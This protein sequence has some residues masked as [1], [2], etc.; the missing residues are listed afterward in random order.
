MG[1]PPPD[2]NRSQRNAAETLDLDAGTAA[3]APGRNAPAN[4]L[5]AARPADHPA[6]DVGDRYEIRHEHARGSHARVLLAFD[7]HTGR[8]VALKEPLAT[9]PSGLPADERAHRFLREARTTAQL[10]HPHIVPVH[11]IGRS[12]DGAPFY[13]MR[14]VRGETLAARLRSCH[15]LA[16]RLR[17]LGPFWDVCRAVAFAHRRGVIHRDLKPANCMVGEHGETVLL[18]W[19]LARGRGAAEPA[20][21]ASA[22]DVVEAPAETTAAPPTAGAD[23]DAAATATGTLLG[24]PSYMSPEQ[25]AGDP[26]A[27]DERADVWGLGAMLYEVLTGAPPFAGPDPLLVLH[28]VRTQAV[29]PVRARC[30]DAPP[31]LAAIAEKALARAPAARYPDAGA[32]VEDV[33]A[34]MTGGRVR[35]YA[36]RV[37]DVVRRLVARHRAAAVAAATVLVVVVA[38]LV[39]VTV[40]YRRESAARHR[41]H[42]ERLTAQLHLA[43]A[44]AQRAQHLLGQRALLSAEVFALAS[45]ASNPASAPGAPRAAEFVARHPASEAARLEARSAL[46]RSRLRH[47]TGL[48]GSFAVEDSARSVAISAD[49]RHLAAADGGGWLRVWDAATLRPAMLVRA[50]EGGAYAVAFS[51]DGRLVAS[52]GKDGTVKLF[53]VGATAPTLTLPVGHVV[54]AI[55]VTPDGQRLATGGVGGQVRLW[56]VATG[57]VLASLAPPHTGQVRGLAFS[58]DGR[59]LASGSWDTTAKIWDARTLALK[60]TLRGHTNSLTRLAFSP[61]G[62]SLATASFDHTVRVWTVANGATRATLAA[63]PAAAH[64]VAFLPD[65]DTVVVGTADRML[66]VW[67]V[68]SN[69]L[70]LVVEAHGDTVFGLGLDDDGRRLV[71]GGLDSVVKLWDLAASDGLTHAWHP[72]VASG[73]LSRDGARLMTTSWDGWVRLWN[74][75]T[76]RLEARLANPGKQI[77]DSLL[78]P[79]GT[80]VATAGQ[81]GVIRLLDAATGAVRRELR[82]HRGEIRSLAVARD[83]ARLASAS[84]DQTV[85]LWDPATGRELAALPHDEDATAAAFA[86]DGSWI[87]TSSW[88][89]R[90]RRWPVVPP[91]TPVSLFLAPD[92]LTRVAVSG[93]GTRVAASCANGEVFVLGSA[94]GASVRSF[95]DHR[96]WVNSLSLSP[97]GRILASGGQDGLAV[98][99]D[100][101]SGEQLLRLDAGRAVEHVGISP[102]GRRLLVAAGDNVVV[103]PLAPPS[104]GPDLAAE[105]RA[106]ER[107]A[108]VRLAGAQLEVA[109][110]TTQR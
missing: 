1:E 17:L 90:V 37:R 69:Q 71:T 15:G 3:P 26:A 86:P 43:E 101:A 49:G 35:A 28:R 27:V 34:Y 110:P 82:G 36:Y 106:A 21:T 77:D 95:R 2:P 93:D 87:V 6:A 33:D 62:D 63:G 60:A 97:D 102:D 41:E 42:D 91:H 68:P 103:Y 67:H 23:A 81:D 75:H 10:D 96:Q 50:H 4:A 45:L 44:H 80:W 53:P 5:P 19:G 89:R 66:R 107:R 100:L 58:R 30:A 25:A 46:Y 79:D 22:V 98:V 84:R 78:A 59:W 57:R 14:F 109:P 8:E 92:R 61:D 39:A 85:R 74:A 52:G 38:A 83:G 31:E 99:R 24:T 11:E 7:R 73:S 20:I 51:P 13:T 48:A 108:G 29:P 64:D 16:E 105:L 70:R 55:A 40:A 104:A 54:R 65:G 88:D 47:I 9:A 76:G 32:L 94:P 12:A 72:P 18:D 56:E